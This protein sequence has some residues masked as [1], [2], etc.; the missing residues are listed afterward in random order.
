MQIFKRNIPIPK[1][2]LWLLLCFIVFHVIICYTFIQ[3][4]NITYDEPSYI[5]YSKR[6]LH[7]K[8]E[9]IEALDD[10]KTPIISIVWLPRIVR[11]IINPNYHLDDYGRKDQEE[12]K[13]MM[14]VFSILTIIYLYKF[15]QLLKLKFWWSIFLFL[16]IDPLFIS[17]SVLINSDVASGFI[18]LALLF[19]LTKYLFYQ[20][21]KQ[22]YFA[23]IFLAFGLVTKHTFLFFVPVFWLFIFWRTKKF[24][25]QKLLWFIVIVLM[26]INTMFYFEHSFKTFGSYVF[27]SN[28]LQHLQ[29][30]FNFLHSLPIPLPANYVHSIDLLQYHSQLGGSK[31]NT[32]T[33]V[34]L[35]GKTKLHGGFWYYYA[36]HVF[37]KFPISILALV[38][39]GTY[40]LVKNFQKNKQQH[41]LLLL[42]I[43]TFV[44]SLSFFNSFQIG[45]RHLLLVLPTLYVLIA[46]VINKLL[47]A[48]KK[49]WVM[50]LWFFMFSSVAFYF[51]YL[52]PYTNEF[53]IHKNKVYEKIMDSSID[54]G[55][56]DSL[57]K[58][59]ILQDTS[60]Q[61]PT[62]F[63]AKGKYL[64]NMKAY[65]EQLKV[66]DT[67]LNW[68]F[69]YHQPKKNIAFVALE[70]QVR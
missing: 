40:F 3:Y 61:M 47:I 6:W 65:I 55:Q 28:T 32:Y 7:G 49:I 14:I 48:H 44:F 30:Q 33:G 52:I 18:L 36:V 4:Q 11:Q 39:T 70:F 51:P 53:V 31:S 37:Y 23:T 9:R 56:S 66:G 38:V 68:L 26:I 57:V 62:A 45:V 17:F 69:K 16:L 60:Y 1:N 63:A 29:Q 12:G 2:H 50:G 42:S 67:S 43:F 5:E 22:F 35:L 10:S 59:M 25:W 58:K 64:V 27:V 20:Q 8:P 34:Y 46:I 21:Q 41:L 15:T 54:Y 13:Y 24:A 19:H